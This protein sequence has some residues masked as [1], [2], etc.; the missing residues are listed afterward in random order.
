[1]ED[2]DHERVSS[3]AFGQADALTSTAS[4][5]NK[6]RS[7]ERHLVP[8]DKAPRRASVASNQDVASSWG[9]LQPVNDLTISQYRKCRYEEDGNAAATVGGIAITGSVNRAH[10]PMRPRRIDVPSP[11]RGERDDDALAARRLDEGTQNRLGPQSP[12]EPS[13][14]YPKSASG[15]TA[16]C[17]RCDSDD[18]KYC[19][20][21]NYN[22]SQPRYYCK[23]RKQ[24]YHVCVF[25]FTVL[26][27]R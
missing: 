11:L 2:N 4:F 7:I 15:K 20:N 5:S 26:V 1:M 10:V 27:S 18:T 13:S 9:E 8:S 3:D 19:Y 6:K 17:P 23:V 22:A 12:T 21:N 16:R 14:V 24:I 25:V